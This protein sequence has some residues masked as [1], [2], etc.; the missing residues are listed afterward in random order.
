MDIHNCRQVINT[1]GFAL[2]ILIMRIPRL[3]NSTPG[4]EAETL[5]TFSNNH[6]QGGC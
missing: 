4:N 5:L 3:E 6:L 2:L 1:L